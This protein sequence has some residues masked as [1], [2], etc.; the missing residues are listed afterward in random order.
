M[1][2]E[3]LDIFPSNP[4]LVCSSCE[5]NLLDLKGNHLLNC[6]PGYRHDMIK[7]YLTK[8]LKLANYSVEVEKKNIYL[9]NSQRPADIFIRNFQGKDTCLDV[10]IINPGTHEHESASNSFPL[11]HLENQ[12][13]KK[14]VKYANTLAN[15]ALLTDGIT[16][17]CLPFVLDTHGSI[18]HEGFK[19]LERISTRIARRNNQNFKLVLKNILKELQFILARAITSQMISSGG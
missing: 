15:P 14:L 3:G 16:K 2:T 7:L 18:H 5:V 4:Q 1:F 8:C 17:Y 6:E 9:D 11:S 19:F 10:T 12:Y 13:K